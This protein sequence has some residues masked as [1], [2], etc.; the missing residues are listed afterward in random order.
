MASG[1]LR[2]REGSESWSSTCS[3]C[4]ARS[5]AIMSVPREFLWPTSLPFSRT[6][7]LHAV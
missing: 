3:S 4:P 5:R 2:L 6:S 7:V 1:R